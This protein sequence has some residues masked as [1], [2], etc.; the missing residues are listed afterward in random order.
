MVSGTVL[1][2]TS[3]ASLGTHEIQGHWLS[4]GDDVDV[5]N[6]KKTIS[7]IVIEEAVLPPPPEPE[8]EP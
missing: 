1:W 2:D 3:T 6:N 7:I 8:S 5:S 4:N